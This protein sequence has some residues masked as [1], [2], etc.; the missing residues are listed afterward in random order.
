MY[1]KKMLSI[2]RDE[3]WAGEFTNDEKLK[4]DV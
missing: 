4:Y 3:R 2:L 1:K